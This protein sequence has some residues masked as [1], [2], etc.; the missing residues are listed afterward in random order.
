MFHVANEV[1]LLQP[2]SHSEPTNPRTADP[3]FERLLLFIS[4]S[5]CA[6]VAGFR[7]FLPGFLSLIC[8]VGPLALAARHPLLELILTNGVWLLIS[9]LSLA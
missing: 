5:P 4:P 7:H 1:Y 6:V 9:Y 3:S 2:P 8:D